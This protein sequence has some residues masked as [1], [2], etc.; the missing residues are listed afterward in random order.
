MACRLALPVHTVPGFA[1]VHQAKINVI[2]ERERGLL[3]REEKVDSRGRRLKEIQ[4]AIARKKEARQFVI[5]EKQRVSEVFGVPG[6]LHNLGRIRGT[7]YGMSGCLGTM[8][9][10][11]PLWEDAHEHCVSGREDYEDAIARNSS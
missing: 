4:A 3:R 6:V 2:L 8:L 10:V 5:Q 1:G 11:H 7:A 9:L